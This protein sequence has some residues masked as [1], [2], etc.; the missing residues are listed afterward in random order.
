V[1]PR[2]PRGASG[3]PRRVRLARQT[4]PPRLLNRVFLARLDDP[5]RYR[6]IAATRSRARQPALGARPG[7]CNPLAPRSRSMVA[8]STR[9]LLGPTPQDEIRRLG[10]KI[11]Q[12]GQAR[13]THGIRSILAQTGERKNQVNGPLTHLKTLPRRRKPW[14]PRRHRRIETC[15]VALAASN[16]AGGIRRLGPKSPH[17][18][19]FNSRDATRPCSDPR[20]SAG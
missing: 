9:R 20:A 7:A 13:L 19:P 15:L 14:P 2:G 16:S 10:P 11:P 18:G 17:D 4:A 3:L 8:D 12:D 1:A 5:R 6:Q